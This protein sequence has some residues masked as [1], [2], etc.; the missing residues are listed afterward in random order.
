MLDKIKTFLNFASE[1]GLKFPYAY[2]KISNGPSVTL[3][4][5]YISFILTLISIIFLF[6]KPDVL[7]PTLCSMML[8]VICLVIYRMRHLDKFKLDLD[9]RSLELK[10]S[11]ENV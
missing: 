8:F 10:S 3:F 9:D 5:C 7:S 6:F 11:D 4:F 1:E 2:D